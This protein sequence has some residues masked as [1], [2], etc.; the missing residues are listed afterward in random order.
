MSVCG[1]AALTKFLVDMG[2]DLYEV[3]V[4]GLTAL[5]YAHGN[6]DPCLNWSNPVLKDLMA[7]TARAQF[8]ISQYETSDIEA[9]VRNTVTLTGHSNDG[10]RARI[11][12]I[13]SLFHLHRATYYQGPV[14]LRYCSVEWYKVNP[15]LL[16]HILCNDDSIDPAAFRAQ[17]PNCP[18][19][20]LHRLIEKWVPL[21]HPHQGNSEYDIQQLISHWRYLL[22]GCWMALKSES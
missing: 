18:R 2:L 5:G 21:N 15:V 4:C 22:G 3:D 16:L 10:L 9:T 1:D 11:W 14:A 20:S 17:L 19:G 7:D 13:P 8:L 6:L 12:P